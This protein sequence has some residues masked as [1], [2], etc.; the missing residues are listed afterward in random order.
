MDIEVFP[1]ATLKWGGRRLTCALGRN[2]VRPDKL[3]G[4]GATPQGRWLLRRVM[5][6]PDRIAPPGTKLPIQ[7]L[8]PTDGWCD[9]PDDAFY[10]QPVTIPYHASH[11]NLWRDDHVYDV[12]VVLG[13]N[14][15]P[16][17]PGSGSAVFMHVARSNFEPTEGCVAMRLEDLLFLINDCGLDTAVIIH[18]SA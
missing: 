4:D 5:Y 7:P 1:P 15:S 11:E 3:E 17:V 14:S 6:R 8:L 2:G 18:P 12:I 13:H 16:I 9:D 10:N